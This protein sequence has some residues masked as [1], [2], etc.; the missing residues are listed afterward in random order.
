MTG[1]ITVVGYPFQ[2]TGM[3]EHARSTFRAFQAA[4]L[5][6]RLLDVADA[7][8]GYDADLERDFAPHLVTTLGAGVNYAF[9]PRS[10]VFFNLAAL[11]A[12]SDVVGATSVGIDDDG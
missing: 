10:S 11:S 4:G 1:E 9:T 8:R 5:Q 6:P 3:A 7:N 2:P 12:S